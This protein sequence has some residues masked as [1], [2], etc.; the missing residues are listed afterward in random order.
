MKNHTC[1]CLIR[2]EKLISKKRMDL[3]SLKR[4]LIVL[5]SLSP[6]YWIYANLC[7]KYGPGKN[8]AFKNLQ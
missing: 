6:S 1:N 8:R 4:A 2:R 7:Y 5:K 3:G